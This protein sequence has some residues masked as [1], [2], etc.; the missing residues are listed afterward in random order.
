MK[1]IFERDNRAQ[2]VKWLLCEHKDLS[3]NPRIYVR[4]VGVV[5]HALDPK[6]SRDKRISAAHWPAFPSQVLVRYPISKNKV[7]GS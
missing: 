3:S 2:F 5:A 4:K 1:T 6:A 7:G